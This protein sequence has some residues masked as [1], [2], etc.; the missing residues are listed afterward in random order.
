MILKLSK[1]KRLQEAQPQISVEK[2]QKLEEAVSEGLSDE[3]ARAEEVEG[4]R[5][6]KV[7]TEVI[8]IT[9]ERIEEL[10]TKVVED[11]VERVVRE[12][13]AEVAQKVIGQAIEALEKSLESAS[14]D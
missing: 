11:V 13:V 6:E 7:T 2:E 12:T 8:G 10:I 9:E 4:A 3:G 5:E 1:L 14:S